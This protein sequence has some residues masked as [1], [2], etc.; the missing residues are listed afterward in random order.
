MK[1]IP[2]HGRASSDS[3]LTLPIVKDSYKKLNKLDFN[4]FKGL[5]SHFAMTA[6]I[7]YKSID[8]KNP[9]THSSIIIRDVIRKKIGFKGNNNF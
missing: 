4:C 5:Q 6:H 8:S 9:A 7:L 2:G 1:H 3:H